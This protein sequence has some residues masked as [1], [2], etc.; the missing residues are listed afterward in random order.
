MKDI[1][2]L[3][4][5]K[6]IVRDHRNSHEHQAYGNRLSEELNDTKHRALYIRL[7]KKEDRNILEMAR[8]FVVSQEHITE[9]G[10]LFMWKLKD[11]KQ[12]KLKKKG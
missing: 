7:A 8:I 2:T 9:K 3:L 10:R 1:K 4:K 11:I 12:K 6:K 5:N